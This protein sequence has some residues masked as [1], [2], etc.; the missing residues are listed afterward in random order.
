MQKIRSK[1]IREVGQNFVQNRFFTL[2][3][4]F[5]SHWDS[6]NERAY[7]VAFTPTGWRKN[8]FLLLMRHFSKVISPVF[9]K[10]NS[11][12]FFLS[13]FLPFF[14]P[15]FLLGASVNGKKFRDQNPKSLIR[16]NVNGKIR[17]AKSAKNAQTQF[18]FFIFC[19]IIFTFKVYL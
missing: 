17:S 9:S 10:K 19:T 2:A 12:F 15:F 8:I 7:R 4:S 13:F 16:A 3:F 11:S 6:R 18:Y 5:V 1:K 14:L